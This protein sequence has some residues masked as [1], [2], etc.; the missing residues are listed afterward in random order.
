M[1]RKR[2]ISR[3]AY[4][5]TGI[6]TVANMETMQFERLDYVVKTI[7]E[8]SEKE[9]IDVLKK[10]YGNSIKLDTVEK[11]EILLVMPEEQYINEASVEQPRKKYETE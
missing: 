3:T 11:N 1:S 2:V 10:E 5:Y 8:L 9:L 4:F 6:I 7:P